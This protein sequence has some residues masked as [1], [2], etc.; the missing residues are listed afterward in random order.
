MFCLA[1]SKFQNLVASGE[2]G[3]Q[4]AI[5]LWDSQTLQNFGIIQGIHKNGIS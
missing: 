5:H 1:V 3:A 4:P 2:I